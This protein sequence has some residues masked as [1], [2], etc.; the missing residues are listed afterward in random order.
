M[1]GC[2]ALYTKSLGSFSIIWL[3]DLKVEKIQSATALYSHGELHSS[4]GTTLYV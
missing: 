4:T 2:V 1:L 3:G